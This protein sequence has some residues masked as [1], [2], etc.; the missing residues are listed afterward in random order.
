VSP[1]S[2]TTFRHSLLQLPTQLRHLHALAWQ[3]WQAT[4]PQKR[5][6]PRT[7]TRLLCV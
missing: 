4:C 3:P 6:D 5:S 7:C 1:L 2:Q